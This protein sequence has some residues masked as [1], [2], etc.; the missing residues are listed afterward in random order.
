MWAAQ[1]TASWVSLPPITAHQL[2]SVC[3]RMPRTHCLTLP[4]RIARPSWLIFTI[5]LCLP[6]CHERESQL[7]LS[8]MLH[9][10]FNLHL[11]YIPLTLSFVLL[12]QMFFLQIPLHTSQMPISLSY[13]ESCLDI[14]SLRREV[15]ITKKR[16]DKAE[17]LL[18]NYTQA[19]SANGGAPVNILQIPEAAIRDYE[20]RIE[21]TENAREEA[22]A[23]RCVITDAWAQVERHLQAA[24]LSAADIR[25]A[26]SCILSAGSGQL[27]LGPLSHSLPSFSHQHPLQPIRM[28]PPPHASRH[29]IS[30][31]RSSSL[32][33]SS[34]ISHP[35]PPFSNFAL[36]P[37]LNPH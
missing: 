29:Q 35:G 27:S 15:A 20:T 32:R 4:L 12:P 14:E 34:T 16:A 1:L 22:D 21:R 17:R 2:N 3:C 10:S 23:R 31:S 7:Y 6:R 33:R 13:S 24:D 37:S 26:F 30:P 19:N 25:S 5:K 8:N 28:P 9:P 18:A 36:P 11:K